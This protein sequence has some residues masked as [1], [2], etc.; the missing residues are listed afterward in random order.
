SP[1]LAAT[2]PTNLQSIGKP[3]ITASCKGGSYRLATAASPMTTISGKKWTS[4]FALVGTNCNTFFTW[5]LNSSFST[6]KA[7][8]ALDASNSGPILVQFRSG[9]V[10]V[11]FV[12]GG[13][14]VSQLKVSASSPIQL[15]VR[16]LRQ[17][18]IVLPNP[19]SDAGIL[20]VT[21]NSLS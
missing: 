2:K 11:K 9:N 7:T 18:S 1:A 21:A 16:S 8:V 17:L 3:A 4:G 14:T 5:R 12:A 6:F 10:P 19:G 15:S 13:K 20:D